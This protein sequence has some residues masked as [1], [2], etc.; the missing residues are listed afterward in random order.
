M[1]NEHGTTLMGSRLWTAAAQDAAANG[2]EADGKHSF[3]DKPSQVQ[4]DFGDRF[5]SSPSK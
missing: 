5:E 1:Q 3:P 4:F 2:I